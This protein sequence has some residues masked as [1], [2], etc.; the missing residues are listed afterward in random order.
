MQTQ[1]E[2]YC[3]RDAIGVACYAWDLSECTD[4]QTP[5]NN[6]DR[7][8]IDPGRDRPHQPPGLAAA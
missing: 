8:A 5:A 4:I 7:A 6:K 2:A 3:L 1:A